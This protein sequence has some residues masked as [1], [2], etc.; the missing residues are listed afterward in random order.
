VAVR[1]HGA[2]RVGLQALREQ[3]RPTPRDRVIE[4]RAVEAERA[5]RRRQLLREIRGELRRLRRVLALGA[6]RDAARERLLVR[7]GVE[8][9]MRG[10]DGGD[11]ADEVSP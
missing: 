11:A 2:P 10:G 8:G 7:A 9:S 3:E 6:D 5:I 4:Q 1:E